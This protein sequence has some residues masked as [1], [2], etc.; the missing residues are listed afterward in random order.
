MIFLK[1]SYVPMDLRQL[2]WLTLQRSTH[3]L[4]ASRWYGR[5]LANVGLLK[6]KQKIIT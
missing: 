3:G 4:E 6:Q 2:R 1:W 5:K